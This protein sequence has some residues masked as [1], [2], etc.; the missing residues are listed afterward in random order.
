MVHAEE[1][2]SMVYAEEIESMVHAD[3]FRT[4]IEARTIEQSATKVF[5]AGV[6]DR[7]LRRKNS[8]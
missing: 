7:S 3:E 5:N 1:I 6:S 8:I 2:E 4:P